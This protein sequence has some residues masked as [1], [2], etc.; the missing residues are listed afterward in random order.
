MN[1]FSYSITPTTT[2]G[3]TVALRTARDGTERPLKNRGGKTMVFVSEVAA[4][5]ALLN[6]LI[7]FVN[8][9]Y[10][11]D[12]EQAGETNAA[13]NAAFKLVKQRGGTRTIS[14]ETK[15]RVVRG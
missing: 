7:A 12:G 3:F 5:T 6:N 9:N 10:Q 4:Y 14:V 15:R 8:G 11:R 13:A 1:C 2:G